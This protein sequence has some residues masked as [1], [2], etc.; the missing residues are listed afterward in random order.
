MK[1][2]ILS[3][4]SLLATIIVSLC[5]VV[6]CAPTDK[7]NLKASVIAT[8][9]TLIFI[10]VEA[11]SSETDKLIDAMTILQENGALEYTVSGGMIQSI[12]GKENKADW[13]ASWMLYTS[14]SEMA[15]TEWT[16]EYDGVTY[17]SAVLGAES[18]PVLEGACYLWVYTYFTFDS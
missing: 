2:K 3:F 16:Y 7:A 5:A 17:G 18:L 13:S 8:T 14:D 10:Q 9:D 4:I 6:G 1:R 15:S 11:V 12:N